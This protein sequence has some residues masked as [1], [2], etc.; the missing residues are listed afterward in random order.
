MPFLPRYPF[1]SSWT[2]CSV[3]QTWW[4]CGHQTQSSAKHLCRV[5]SS[6]SPVYTNWGWSRPFKSTQKFLSGWCASWCVG[7]G[8]TSSLWCY[9]YLSTPV[10]LLDA[11]NSAGV[12]AYTAV[13]QKHS[14]SDPKY[15]ELGWVCVPLEVESYGNWGK[16]TQNSFSRQASILSI[17]QHCPKAKVMSEIYGRLNIF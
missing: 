4:G 10:T 12:V 9:S 5:L 17:S 2:S 13:C 15:Q 16:E 6:C 8:K 1:R 14:S 7:K 3:M 11:C